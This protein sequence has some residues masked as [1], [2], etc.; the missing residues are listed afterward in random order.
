MDSKMWP[1]DLIQFGFIFKFSYFML[2]LSFLAWCKQ[3]NQIIPDFTLICEFGLEIHLF[4]DITH[5]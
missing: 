5:H 1:Y 4:Q 3:P 2:F